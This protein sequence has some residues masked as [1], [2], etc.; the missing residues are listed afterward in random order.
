MR[1][2]KGTRRAASATAFGAIAL[3]GMA[4]GGMAL[5]GMALGG[6]ALG[7]A[8]VGPAA[9][10][11][12]V[13]HK[14]AAEAAAHRAETDAAE[15]A[16]RAAAAPSGAPPS[17]AAP[18]GLF[19]D[20]FGGG[21]ALI[22]QDGAPRTE[23]DPDGRPQLVFFGYAGCEAICSVALPKVAAAAAALEADGVMATPVMITVDPEHDTPEAMK[24]ALRALHPRFI[25]LTGSEAALAEAERAFQ[26]T[27]KQVAV[28]EDGESPIY[29][30]GSFIYLVDGEGAFLTLMPP[31]QSVEWMV[32]TIKGYVAPETTRSGAAGG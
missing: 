11:N 20:V 17:I 25:G 9:A 4:L 12:G 8:S 22:D 5:G 21:Y 15:R 26:V 31:I 1:R 6:M 2:A 23:A 28:A 27:S 7:L 16:A 10:H 18:G 14:N 29:A 30:H 3:G 24:E 32:A 13:V 19:P